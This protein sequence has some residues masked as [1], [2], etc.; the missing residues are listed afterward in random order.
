MQ[1]D[2]GT[3]VD[4]YIPRKWFPFLL[5]LFHIAFNSSLL[6]HVNPM[7]FT[8]SSW[9][10]RLLAAND[11]GAIQVNLANIDPVTGLFTK[12]YSTVA[13]CGFLRQRGEVDEALTELGKKTYDRD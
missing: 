4:L 5:Y 1:N 2:E 9:T 10:N 8:F 11:H 13:L 6:F 3:V 7:Y 12:T